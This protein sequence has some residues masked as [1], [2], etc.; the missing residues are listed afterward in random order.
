MLATLLLSQ[1][2]PMFV[3]G[4][5]ARRTQRGNNNAYCQDNEIS[6]FDWNLV[7][8]NKDLVRFVQGLIDFRRNQP[9]VRRKRFSR[10]SPS[11]KGGLPDVSW[12]SAL[13]T[14][15]DWGGDD[16]ALIALLSAPLPEDDP[17]QQGRDVMLFFNATGQPREFIMPAVAKGTNWRLFIDTSAAPPHDIYP[18]RNGPPLP[19]S[20]RLTLTYRSL[21][22]YVAE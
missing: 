22:C 3:Y 21:C 11:A 14:A 4:D 10:G 1:G 6:W 16:A 15:V 13:G 17:L 18:D 8:Q 20:Q 7:G 2:V 19:K 12:Y 5:E 9:T